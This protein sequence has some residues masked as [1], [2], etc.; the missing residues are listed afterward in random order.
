MNSDKTPT[1]GRPRSA[2]A[3]S[4]GNLS[5][6]EIVDA[7]LRIVQVEGVDKLSMRRLS[8]ELG[9][10]A[11]APYYYVAD[12]EALLD[13]VA[14]A[15]LSDINLPTTAS[16]P[17][18]ERLRSVLDQIDEKLR[19]HPGIGELLLNQMLHKQRQLVSAIMDV[20]FDAGFS[21][22]DVLLAYSMIHSY[23]FG[24]N[25]ATREELTVSNTTLPPTLQRVTP[26]VSDLRG[27]DFYDFGISTLIAGLES[28]LGST[29]TRG[30]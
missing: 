14:S 26:H 6:A 12:K 8:R 28:Q 10:S 2:R 29:T 27:R 1:L 21:E 9:A 17:W 22:R 19:T 11:M 24:R 13:L 5:E 3:E 30:Y 23:L 18:Q 15:A 16:G 4:A 25:R 20:L 7:A